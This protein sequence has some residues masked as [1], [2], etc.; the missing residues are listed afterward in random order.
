MLTVITISE[1]IYLYYMFTHFKTTFNVNHPLEFAIQK[2]I[3]KYFH[4]PISTDEYSNK[5]CPFGKDAIKILCGFLLIRLII[6]NFKILSK[7]LL[8]KV[9][10][11]VLVI[12]LVISF[13]SMNAVVYLIPFFLSEI[14]LYYRYLR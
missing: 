13:M 8:R 12:T 6:F 3:D 2:K 5:I 4:H 11:I 7:Y 1:I 14:N 9:T 10:Q